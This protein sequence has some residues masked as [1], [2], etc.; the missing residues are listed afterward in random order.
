MSCARFEEKNYLSKFALILSAVALMAFVAVPAA[1]ASFGL[2]DFDVTFTNADGS[3]AT[4]AGSHPF[5][6]TTSFD[7]N[8][9]VDSKLG[10]IPDDEIKDFGVELP[11]GFAGN[12]TATPRCSAVDFVSHDPVTNASLCPNST[13][14][15]VVVNEIVNLGPENRK[16]EPVF[17]LVPPPGVAAE[18]GFLVDTVVPVTVDIGVNGEYPNNI[19]ASLVNIPQPV[20]VFGSVLTIW[21]NPA[22]PAH[23]ADR[24]SCAEQ[25]G[26]SCPTSSSNVP[27]LTLPRTCTGPLITNWEVVSWQNPAGP[28][29]RGFAQTHDNSEPLL[30]QGLSGCS[31]LGFA[32]HIS[33]QPSTSSAESASGLNFNLDIDDEG[34]TSP[35]GIAQSDIKKAVVTMPPGVTINP[36]AAGGLET[37]STANYEAETISSQPGQGCPE[38]SKIGAVEVETPLLEGELIKGS[39]FVAAQ[40]ANPFGSLLAIYIVFKDPKLGVLVKVAGKVEPNDEHGPRAG[41]LVTTFDEIPQIPFAHLRFHFREGARAPLVTPPV[42]GKYDT[43]AQFTPWAD[44]S[45][46]ITTTAA[47]T[48]NSGV[49]GSL[50]PSGAVPFRPTFEAGSTNNNAGSYSPFYIRLARHD[51]E[52]EI[53]RVSSVLPPG[54]VGK[55]AG[56][57]RCPQASADA[58]K[59]KTGSQ[60]LATPSC[61]AS[62]EIGRVLGGAGV[63][64]ALTYV[65]GKVYLGGP[66]G[67]DP[68]SVIVITPAVAGPFDIGTVVVQ[69]GLKLNRETAQVEVD[70]AASAPIPHILKGIPLKL[71]DLRVYVDR[72][73][74]MLNPTNCAAFSVRA[75][76]FGDGANVFDPSD[77]SPA[78]LFARYQ[79]ANCATLRFKPKLSFRLAGGTKRGAHPAL[80]AVVDYPPGGGYANVGKA[81]VTLPH[82]AFLE[83]SH[84]RTVCTRV[85]FAANQCPAGSIYGHAR[86]IT[87]LLDEP[88]EGPVYLRSSSHPLPD[89]VVA[90]HGLVDVDLVGRVDSVHARIRTSFESVPDAPVSKFVLEMQGG[91]K[92]LVVNSRNLCA[93]PSRAIAA[94]TA[95]NGKFVEAQPAV[96]ATGCSKA[97][98]K[99]HR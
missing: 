16:P 83:Q 48:I 1:D 98:P 29:V 77:D 82:S 89:L 66:F 42:C 26:D 79:A 12:P 44:P 85:Q 11:V 30:P 25:S 27:F 53:T 92:G 65:P 3:P 36:S 60:E 80:R 59:A 18:L 78:S 34:L 97:K 40:N 99:R 21:G 35:T 90:L 61:P 41:Q 7:V 70:S 23:D 52:Q 51:H 33:A 45:R 56:L 46:P 8:T 95:Q 94:L 32:P 13:A 31:K 5:A 62:S 63:G 14:V 86:A 10:V 28:P 71:R 88:L 93:H 38:A 49:D 39:V 50:C 74:F 55:I 84:I 72:R 69:V 24:G 87:P 4:Q 2:K 81:I 91:K 19:R 76:L 37:C 75:T 96:K 17:N 68:L 20:A 22:A 43:E 64:S 15:G 54:V 57:S 47:F 6:M 67:G 58:A 73:D 9:K